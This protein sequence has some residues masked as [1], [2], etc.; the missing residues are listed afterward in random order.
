MDHDYNINKSP[1]KIKQQLD[2]S[3][4]EIIKLRKKLKNKQQQAR[5]M[6]LR[7]KHLKT[8][9]KDLRQRNLITSACEEML[10]TTF[11]G[12]PRE[13]MKRMTS[14][15][16]T[17]K[18]SVYSPELRSFALTLQF[19][20]SKAYEF[21]RKTFNLALPHQAQ[22]RRWYSKIPA[23]PGF[24]EPAFK[25]LASKVD[26]SKKD[27][28]QVICS[29]MID[30]MAIKKHVCWDGKRY[31]GYVD[32]GNDIVDDTTPVA[33]EA[34]VF[35]VVSINNSWKVPC[36]Y[37]FIDGLDGA[38][39]ANLVKICLKKL[40][41]QGVKIVSLICDGPACH[42]TM[43]SELGVC[44][45]P[46]K[47]K[48]FFPHPLNPSEKV[49][50][51]LDVCHML[52]L[53]RNTFSEGGLLVDKSGNK[54]YWQF[55]TEL[56]KLQD[57]E[58]LRLGN[59]LKTAH[60]QW[61][62]QKMKVNLAA[63]ALSSSVADAI[64]YC[65]D[66]L[67]LPQFQGSSATIKFIRIFDQLFDILN[68]RNPFAK[69]YKAPLRVQNKASW[70]SF[71]DSAFEYILGLKDTQGTLMYE[72]RRKTGFLGFLMA[73]KSTKEIFH[74]YVEKETAPLKYLLTYKL[75]QDHIELFFGAIRSAGGFN[76]NPTALQFTSAYKRLLLRSSIQG[77]KGNCQ[78]VDE[79]QLLFCFDDT[80]KVGD[81]D[82]SI[83]DAAVIRKYG[84]D[85]TG[86]LENDHDYCKAPNIGQLSEYKKA[87]IS[88]IAGYV[89][90]MV[91]KIT[92][93]RTC[94]ESLGSKQSKT[95]SSFLKMKD[96]GGLFKP[97][98]SVIRVCEETER[99]FQLLLYS[100]KGKLPQGNSIAKVM[101]KSIVCQIYARVL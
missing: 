82:F 59:K 2:K 6:K 88:Y 83:T 72:T 48:T 14:G 96:R 93:C 50:V 52:K 62:Q 91:E 55:I 30:E 75:S 44:L 89:A 32:I 66:V 38:E 43:F 26:Q 100:T 35:M 25:A 39:Q 77:G 85:G 13:L 5:R 37:F 87:A 21:V 47:L 49:Y 95:V 29:L 19:Y 74:D 99:N 11:S 9:V 1:R 60:I 64:Q 18:G 67:K 56:Q 79:T 86:S 53:I 46:K 98:Q 73:I 34:L 22:I 27:G 31:R 84:L 16:R 61:K 57:K 69:G 36:G 81:S 7:V 8:V 45:K 28:K 42:L 78:K 65:S 33:K 76:N 3:N 80:C 15:K 40:Y 70:S 97:T 92:F 90:K 10:N 71:L 4:D 94:C 12:V 41:E 51:L 17:G 58:G 101:K 20:S 24:T 54:V 68:S 23:E 63:Q